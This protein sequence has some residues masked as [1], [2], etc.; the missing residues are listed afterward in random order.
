MGYSLDNELNATVTGN[1]TIQGLLAG[2]HTLVIYANDTAGNMGKSD[3]VSFTIDT[4]PSP[5][6]TLSPSNSPTQQP[7]IEPSPTLDNIQA[8][9]F[10]PTIIILALVAIAV[11]IGFLAYFAKHKGWK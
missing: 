1:T 2:Y 9:N 11:V 10:T 5:S 3:T 8:D 6:P 7:T 4:Q